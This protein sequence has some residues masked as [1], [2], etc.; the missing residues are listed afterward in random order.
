MSVNPMS[1][2][3]L[4]RESRVME[5]T[6]RVLLILMVMDVLAARFSSAVINLDSVESTTS[7]SAEIIE[8]EAKFPPDIWTS[9][10]NG[11]GDPDLLN[12]D[13]SFFGL[14]TLEI[15]QQIK[16]DSRENYLSATEKYPWQN[17]WFKDYGKF[18][19]NRKNND[20]LFDQN[21]VTNVTAQLGGTAFLHCRVKNLGERPVSWVRRR[22]WHILTSGVFTYT[23]DERFQVA[24]TEGADDWTLQIKYVQKRDN[25]TYECQVATGSGT[26]SH[27]FNLH[28]VV[29]E[30]FI[31]GSGEY[32]IGEGSTIS[33]VCIIENSPAPPQYVFWYHNERMINYDT[34]RGG[35]TVS[36]EPGPKTHS[37]LIINNAKLTDSGNYSCRASNTDPDFI[38][39]FVSKGDKPA[40]IQRQQRNSGSERMF[41]PVTTSLWCWLLTLHFYAR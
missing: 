24:H 4:H 21:M 18:R 13:F 28:I 34:S 9:I 14:H 11:S 35:V 15:D 17:P 3:A 39:V 31:L 27:Y 10:L 1:F 19:K 25:G 30:A 6:R 32:H 12:V 29:P 36:T 26:M 23:N 37:R 38:Q 41:A 33:L 5:A 20:P 2:V 16:A 22:D 8:E 7:Q 40:A